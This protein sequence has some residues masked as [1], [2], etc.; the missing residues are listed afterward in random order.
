MKKFVK[1]FLF[2][3]LGT[4]FMSASAQTIVSELVKD[5]DMQ[6]L[7][8]WYTQ[9]QHRDELPVTYSRMRS[10]TPSAH[11]L[12]TERARIPDKS[13]E[14]GVKKYYYIKNAATGEYLSY[15]KDADL[16]MTKTPNDSAK[17][18][19]AEVNWNSRDEGGFICNF[20]NQDR[21]SVV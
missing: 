13:V 11:S 18:F 6:E 8:S 19:Y 21:K 7:L 9:S 14:G 15:G 5:V 1:F 10:S 20:Y 16:R 17:F 3:C 12:A 4:F 2:M